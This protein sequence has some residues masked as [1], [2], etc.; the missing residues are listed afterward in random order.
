MIAVTE[1]IILETLQNFLQ[2][3]VVSKIKLQRPTDDKTYELVNPVVH[4]G[5]IPPKLPENLMPEDMIKDIPSIPCIVVGLDGGEDDG[6]DASMD[7]RLTFVTYNRGQIKNGKLLPDFDGYKDVINLR[8]LAREELA[9]A[10]VIGKKTTVQQPFAWG[11]YEEQ[12]Y[13]HWVGWMKFKVTCAS[14]IYVPGILDQ[15]I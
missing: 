1:N 8:T 6:T 3:N 7:I 14:M 12:P 2:E 15:Y 13:P 11:M 10:A 9:K 4:V 5:W